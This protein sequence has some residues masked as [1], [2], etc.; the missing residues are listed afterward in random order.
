MRRFFEAKLI[1]AAAI[2]LILTITV[3]IFNIFS[4]LPHEHPLLGIF[5]FSL[6]PILFITGAI[7]FVLAILRS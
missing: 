4:R 7:V 6:V 2:V 5:T 3:V 1:R